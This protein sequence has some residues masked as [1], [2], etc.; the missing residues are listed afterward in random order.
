MNRESVDNCVRMI[1]PALLAY[2]LECLDPT[3]VN[4]E[5]GSMKEA[6]ILL[7]DTFLNVIL[8]YGENIQAWE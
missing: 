1:E 8:W 6:S 4:L 3:P 5:E 7:L 2:R